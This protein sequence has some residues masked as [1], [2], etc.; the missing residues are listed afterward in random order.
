MMEEDGLRSERIPAERIKRVHEGARLSVACRKIL[1]NARGEA[2]TVGM[3][4]LSEMERVF[5]ERQVACRRFFSCLQ[6]DSNWIV[7]RGRGMRFI[8][9][10][11]YPG[12]G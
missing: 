2:A 10:P 8:S 12:R 7:V 3:S 1:A 6:A 11:L 5:S 9:H 4:L